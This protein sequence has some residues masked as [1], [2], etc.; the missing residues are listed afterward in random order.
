MTLYPQILYI[1]NPII[2][3][4]LWLLAT[5]NKDMQF[6]KYLMLTF[7]WLQQKDIIAKP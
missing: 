1:F 2:V 3:Q 4:K 7:I 6:P 5:L